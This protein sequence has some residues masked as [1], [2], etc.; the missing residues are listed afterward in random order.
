MTS[1]AGRVRGI[2]G[3]KRDVLLSQDYYAPTNGD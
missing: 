2:Y 1:F 3:V